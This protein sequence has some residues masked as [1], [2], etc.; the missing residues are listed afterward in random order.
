LIET[1]KTEAITQ[2][3]HYKNSTVFS[4]RTD[5]RFLAVVFIGKKDYFVEEV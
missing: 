1:K 4:D 2:L 5:V 3:Q